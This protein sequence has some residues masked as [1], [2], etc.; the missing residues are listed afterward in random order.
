MISTYCPLPFKHA[1]VD[2]TG[3]SVCCQSP[4]HQVD[5]NHWHN[6]NK[7]IKMQQQILG[8]QIP[9]TC[10]GCI[11][12]EKIYGQSLR[13]ESLRDYNNQ[14]FTH[15]QLD[16]ID[17]R[18]SN[19]CNFKC[20]SCSPTFSHGIDQE[21]RKNESLTKFYYKVNDTKTVSVNEH[22]QEWILQN[23]N[24]I[25]RLMFTGGEPTQIPGIKEIINEVAKKYKDRINIM[26]TSNA[27]FLDDFWFNVTR[28]LGNIHWTISIDAVGS[29]AEIIR[30]GTDWAVVES[31][32][33]WLAK[34]SPSLDI[35]TVVSNLSVFQLRKLL[36]FVRELQLSSISPNGQ[37]GDIG[38]RHQF[39]VCRSPYMLAVNNLT[40]DLKSSAMNILSQCL[41]LDL[42]SEQSNTLT[43]I[44]KQL[45]TSDFNK[46]QWAISEEFNQTLDR[47]RNEDH[48]VLFKEII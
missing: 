15:T 28:Q 33:R 41:A 19:I 39:F 32:A 8:N 26:I 2:S 45:T 36:I 1:F 11:N 27:S 22:N 14:I 23:L 25:N 9:T 10:Q 38:C 3:V 42:D 21:A 17:Y 24:T 46:E 7:L 5:L 16:F 20:R 40:P 6:D 34:N 43:G 18:S 12:N 31:N 44:L 37:H 30:H 29:A 13:T 48:T 35:N 47:I 4:R